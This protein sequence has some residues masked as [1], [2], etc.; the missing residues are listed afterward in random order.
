M[1]K[2]YVQPETAIFEMELQEVVA[3]SVDV[4]NSQAADANCEVQISRCRNRDTD[5]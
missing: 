1:K 2:I 3:T 5:W 4:N